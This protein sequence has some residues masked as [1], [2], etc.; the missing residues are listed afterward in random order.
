MSSTNISDLGQQVY[1]R[2]LIAKIKTDTLTLQNQIS[3]GKRGEVF[4]DLG[5]VDALQSLSLRAD[6]EK[7]DSYM[8][9]VALVKSRT[10]VMNAGM[11]ELQ[12]NAG[13]LV[14]NLIGP[15]QNTQKDPGMVS[16]SEI[17]KKDLQTL[18][19]RL[20]TKYQGVQLFAGADI[21]NAPLDSA[22]VQ[23][24]IQTEL[25]AMYNGT[26]TGATTITNVKNLGSTAATNGDLGFNGTVGTAGPLSA[27]VDDGVTV[28]YTIK[29]DDAAFKDLIR[30]LSIIANLKYP[31]AT[32]NPAYTDKEF[33]DTYNGARALIE[34]SGKDIAVLQ[35]KVG[36]VQA[37]L[38]VT[39]TKH[40][41][42]M[43]SL[44]EF[45]G[46][47]EDV[48]PADALAKL[49]SLQTQLEASYRIM[50]QLRDL[51]LVNF[52]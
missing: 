26:Q 51:S 28:D 25:T 52:L 15:A 40:E 35:G 4:S 36:V 19:E 3:S 30:G 33:W 1:L 11:E 45:I 12:S 18:I 7:I 14:A 38:D 20:N 21:T 49:T 2:N 22:T 31:D 42:M 8:K 39:T 16:L 37:G 47:A 50:A 34:K 5:G 41:R 24:D 23:T 27:T 43:D 32:T 17:A 13:D 6:R 29:A 48:D 10:T 44:E 9:S 46:D